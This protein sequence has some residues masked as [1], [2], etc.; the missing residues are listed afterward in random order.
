VLAKGTM[1]RGQ[2]VDAKVSGRVKGRESLELRLTEI[3]RG[4][5]RSI[6]ISTKPYTAVAD[7]TRSDPCAP[8]VASRKEVRF[9]PEYPL[10][11]ALAGPIEV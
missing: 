1:V 3:V 11:F 8:S 5:G 9:E 4:N 7:A 2:V 6:D 10:S